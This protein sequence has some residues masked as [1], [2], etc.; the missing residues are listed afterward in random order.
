MP[1]DSTISQPML[2]TWRRLINDRVLQVGTKVAAINL[3]GRVGKVRDETHKAVGVDDKGNP[4]FFILANT[5]TD[6]DIVKRGAE[7]ATMIRGRLP[8]PICFTIA[9]P[10]LVE[11]VDGI[12]FAAYDHHYPLRRGRVMRRQQDLITLP[13][14]TRWLTDAVGVSQQP[15]EDIAEVE[16]HLNGILDC[17]ELSSPVRDFAAEAIAK[18]RAKEWH[19]KYTL[20]H[21]DMWRDNVLRA[22]AKVHGS[23]IAVIDWPGGTMRGYPFYDLLRLL[24]SFTMS[25][26]YAKRAIRAHCRALRCDFEEIGWYLAAALGRLYRNINNYRYDRYLQLTENVF[27]YARRSVSIT[28]PRFKPEPIR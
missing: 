3:H 9:A 11:V 2:D 13:M 1:D 6:D 26:F 21:D 8:E 12:R 23:P 25:N 24:I 10:R 22:D 20:M 16:Y 17:P 4:V 27:D 18:L 15:A 14:I 19:P 28:S 5:A 7:N